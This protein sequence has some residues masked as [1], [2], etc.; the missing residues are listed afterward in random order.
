MEPE[1]NIQVTI[2]EEIERFLEV[3]LIL[4]D[5]GVSLDLILRVFAKHLLSKIINK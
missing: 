4:N 1:Q 3:A 5:E 2:D